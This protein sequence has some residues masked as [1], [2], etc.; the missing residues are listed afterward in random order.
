MRIT[1]QKWPVKR[2]IIMLIMVFLIIPIYYLPAN[3]S[4]ECN[5]EWDYIEWGH[6][7]KKIDDEY[8][9]TRYECTKC[10]ATKIEKEKHKWRHYETKIKATPKKAGVDTYKCQECGCLINKEFQWKYNN[11]KSLSYDI[12]KHQ[13]IY[14][15]SRTVT[16]W[17]ERGLKGSTIKVKI[18]NKTY[19]K[20][21]TSNKKKV[22]MKIKGQKYGT[23]VT[24]TLNYKGKVVG[25]DKSDGMFKKVLY[26]DDIKLGMTKKQVRYTFGFGNPKRTYV[27]YSGHTVWDYGPGT[28]VKFD[29]DKV[30]EAQ[31]TVA[32]EIWALR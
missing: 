26:A 24:V 21:L 17:L 3:G 27:D 28:Y 20:K 19:K 5:H 23:K 13:V 29:G 22:K 2:A 8:H 7:R 4:E 15:N 31:C 30:I 6:I 18:G 10:S 11:W 25:K 12:V 32:S 9:E 1:M 16:I 14:E